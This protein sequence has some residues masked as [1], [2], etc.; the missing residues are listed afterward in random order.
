MGI[1]WNDK[2]LNIKWPIKKP[3]LSLKDQNN[4]SVSSINF[5]NFKDL[6]KL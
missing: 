6:K 5:N 4:L 3:I 1:M 2:T